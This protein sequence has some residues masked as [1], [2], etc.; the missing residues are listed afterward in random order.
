MLL[1]SSQPKVGAS[2]KDSKRTEVIVISEEDGRLQRNNILSRLMMQRACN[3]E[4]IWLDDDRE[5]HVES[6]M[7]NRNWENR[8]RM[9]ATTTSFTVLEEAIYEHEKRESSRWVGGNRSRNKMDGYTEREDLGQSIQEVDDGGANGDVMNSSNRKEGDGILE[10]VL[11]K[12][13][14]G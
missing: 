10:V 8:D 3:S 2:Q 9:Q 11:P 7:F 5:N 4:P 12:K 13:R 6:D 14:R 1:T